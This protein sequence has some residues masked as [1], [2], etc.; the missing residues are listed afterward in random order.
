M[1]SEGDVI[2]PGLS[3]RYMFLA[4]PGYLFLGLPPPPQTLTGFERVRLLVVDE[5][6][7][8]GAGTLMSSYYR[9]PRMTKM[10]CA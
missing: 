3:G 2:T 10:V 8:L 9:C 6:I 7:S 4:D 1:V 5:V